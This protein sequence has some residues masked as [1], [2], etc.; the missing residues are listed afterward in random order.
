MGNFHSY[1]VKFVESHGNLQKLLMVVEN[2]IVVKT[3]DF[4]YLYGKIELFVV[5]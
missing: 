2:L 3:N 4:A 1:L 5:S